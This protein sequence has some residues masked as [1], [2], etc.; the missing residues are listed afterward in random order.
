MFLVLAGGT[1]WAV[2]EWTGANIVNESLTGP[3]RQGGHSAG[4]PTCS[5]RAS[6]RWRNADRLDN[7]NSSRFVQGAS[8]VPGVFGVPTAKSYFNRITNPADSG[9]STMLV[10]PG[11]LHLEAECTATAAELTVWS[12]VNGLDAFHHRDGQ[13]VRRDTLDI[14]FGL[15]TAATSPPNSTR[16]M[17]FQAGLGANTFGLQDLVTIEA[18]IARDSATE[19]CTFQ[20]SALVQRT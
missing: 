9:T 13:P 7:L 20:A 10:V 14:G 17:T 8:A 5:R 19:D 6:A 3:G 12:D 1:A 16:H 2:N 4:G 11:I 18:F 15:T